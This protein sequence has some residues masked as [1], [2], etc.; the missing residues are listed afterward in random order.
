[1]KKIHDNKM[2]KSKQ[3][4]YWLRNKT[5]AVVLK[6][7]VIAINLDKGTEQMW[8]HRRREW[9]FVTHRSEPVDPSLRNSALHPQ[10]KWVTVYPKH[11][12]LNTKTQNPY[13]TLNPKT[14]EH[15]FQPFFPKL[16]RC[17]KQIA[18]TSKFPSPKTRQN[19]WTTMKQPF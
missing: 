16:R 15:A 6:D 4:G 17:G 1:M 12:S 14:G 18:K 19:N 13:I 10:Q 5:H 3:G 2:R 11:W 7:S 9:R 8:M